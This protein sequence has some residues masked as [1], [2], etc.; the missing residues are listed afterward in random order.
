MLE[1]N[2]RE[3]KH[4]MENSPWTTFQKL[5]MEQ[6]KQSGEEGGGLTEDDFEKLKQMPKMTSTERKVCYIRDCEEPN[7]HGML[8]C[9]VDIGI[10]GVH[11]E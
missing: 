7:L 4:Q 11:E 2:F 3:L 10:H 9:G 5:L 8:L 6:V 1:K